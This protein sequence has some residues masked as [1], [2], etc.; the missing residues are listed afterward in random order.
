VKSILQTLV[1]ISRQHL[2]TRFTD[3]LRLGLLE[4]VLGPPPCGCSGW[5]AA[6]CWGC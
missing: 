5:A 4:K 1:G 6:N 3:Q 2:I